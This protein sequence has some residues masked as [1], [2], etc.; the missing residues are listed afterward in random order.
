MILVKH[1]SRARDRFDWVHDHAATVMLV[2]L[3]IQTAVQMQLAPA[4]R[5]LGVICVLSQSVTAY[6][7]LQL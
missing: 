4:H 3:I 6:M 5:C 2:V 7:K 1:L